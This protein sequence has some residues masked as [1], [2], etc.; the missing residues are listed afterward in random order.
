[1]NKQ[2]IAPSVNTDLTQNS[3][4]LVDWQEALAT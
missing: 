3:T 4:S 1:M 2:S